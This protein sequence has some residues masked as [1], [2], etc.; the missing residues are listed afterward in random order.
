MIKES[1]AEVIVI[2]LYIFSVP[3]LH[4]LGAA[5]FIVHVIIIRSYF[6]PLFN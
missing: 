1:F 2:G 4:A 3:Y 6:S 5:F